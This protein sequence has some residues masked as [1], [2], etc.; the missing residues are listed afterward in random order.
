[1]A[2]EDRFMIDEDRLK[3]EE[4]FRVEVVIPDPLNYKALA[5]DLLKLAVT[6]LSAGLLYG[7]WQGMQ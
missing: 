6:I 4:G 3:E 5:V 1:M 2:Q 7:W